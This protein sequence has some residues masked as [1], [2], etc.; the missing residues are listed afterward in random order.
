MSKRKKRLEKKIASLD[1]R[2]AEHERKK[3]EYTGKEVYI[4]P[5]WESEIQDL[6]HEKERAL[7]LLERKKKSR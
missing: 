4:R 3:A 6:I 5:Y 7:G 2:I 1:E